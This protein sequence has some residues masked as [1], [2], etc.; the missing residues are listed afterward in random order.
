MYRLLDEGDE[1]MW[2]CVFVEV[3]V[4]YYECFGVWISCA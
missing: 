4:M 3:V 1:D 2:Y